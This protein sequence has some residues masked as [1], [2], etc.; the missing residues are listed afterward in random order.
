MKNEM[1]KKPK[2]QNLLT[3]QKEKVWF[4]INTFFTIMYLCWRI[5]FTIPVEYGVIST[6]AGLALLLVEVLGMIEAMVHYVNMSVVR[7]YDL[8]QVAEELY[9]DVDIF[10]ATCG[11]EEGVLYKTINGCKRMIYPDKKKVHIYLCD[12]KKSTKVRKLAERMKINYLDRADNAGAKAGNLNNALKH[13][14]SRFVVTFDADMIPQKEFLLKT[15][16]YF[17]DADLKN[18]NKKEEDKIKL[19]FVQTPQAFYT[20]D[21]FQF[22]LYSERVIPNEQDYFYKDIQRSR[23]R[24]NS[25]IYGG[26]NTVLAREALEKIGGFYTESITEDFATGMLIQKAGYVSLGVD[27]ALASGMSV[28][29][30]P[31]LI[32]QRIR[33]GRGVIG[34]LRKMNIFTSKELS[35]GQKINYWASMWYWYAPFKRLIYIMSPLLY[36]VFGITVVKCDLPQVLL[37]WLPMFVTSSISLNMLSGNIR[38]SKWTGIYETILFPFMLGPILMESFGISL[39]IFKVTDKNSRQG[40]KGHNLR[41]KFPFAVL[42]VLSVIGLIRCILLAIMGHTLGPIVVIFWIV[43]NL[44]LLVMCMFFA[45]GREERRKYERVRIAI[46][47]T[48]YYEDYKIPGITRNASEG[49]ISILL[50]KPYYFPKKSKLKVVFDDDRDN[51]GIYPTVMAKVVYSNQIDNKWNYSMKIR[52]FGNSKKDTYNEYLQMLYD[53]DPIFPEEIHEE[54]G[55]LKDLKRNAEQRMTDNEEEDR[56]YPRITI[57]KMLDYAINEEEL[58]NKDTNKKV[59]VEDYNFCY[60]CVKKVDLSLPKSFCLLIDETHNCYLKCEF[61]KTLSHGMLL[62]KVINID[63]ISYNMKKMTLLQDWMIECHRNAK[64]NKVFV[65]DSKA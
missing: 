30:L 54:S 20:P 1:T 21:L 42:I 60:I 56:L 4:V 8:P 17:I 43:Y 15:I 39:K 13:S 46:P 53:R 9:P 52:S 63:E 61:E 40:D 44:Y 24:T 18:E 57:K 45:D 51:N 7:K 62:Y 3:I 38:D 58:E 33:W 64:G 5:F 37:F 41:Y 22:N 26:T 11:E 27:D 49:G 31:G 47:C 55:V 19:G 32:K 59:Y 2:L 16:P 50:D 65:E 36:G 23:T 25:V 28:T 48:I 12:D 35:F 10:I 29:D 6:V 34:T 14:S